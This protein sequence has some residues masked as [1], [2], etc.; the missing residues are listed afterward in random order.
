MNHKYFSLSFLIHLEKKGLIYMPRKVIF[1]L[2]TFPENLFNQS[3]N[4]VL[5]TIVINTSAGNSFSDYV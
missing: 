4:P 1:L 5:I 2:K 3:N